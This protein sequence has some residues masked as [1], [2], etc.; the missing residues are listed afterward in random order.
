M[1]SYPATCHAEDRERCVF[2]VGGVCSV[3]GCVVPGGSST[4]SVWSL[5]SVAVVSVGMDGGSRSVPPGWSCSVGV[6]GTPPGGVFGGV[7][8]PG[9]RSMQMW[10]MCGLLCAMQQ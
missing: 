10:Q 8:S 4:V 1:S 9:L 2:P 3:P 6:G 7:V 5:V